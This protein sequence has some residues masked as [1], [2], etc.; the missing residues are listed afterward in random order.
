ML[1][2]PDLAEMQ[3]LKHY[4]QWL[5]LNEQSSGQSLAHAIAREKK[6]RRSGEHARWHGTLRD[7]GLTGKAD[8]AISMRCPLMA[9]SVVERWP[10]RWRVIGVIS[11]CKRSQG[12]CR[13]GMHAGWLV[14]GREN[15]A[16]STRR[17]RQDRRETIATSTAEKTPSRR[18][19]WDRAKRITFG[20]GAGARARKSRVGNNSI[21][22]SLV[23]RPFPKACRYRQGPGGFCCRQLARSPAPSDSS[24]LDRGGE[25][26]G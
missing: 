24:D 7:T 2:R 12:V 25:L 26:G 10:R 21:T 9:I 4:S 11:R 8:M 23:L 20:G 3:A 17:C 6:Q 22:T 16:T 15:C 14:A 19:Q 18:G 5:D 13:L 1:L